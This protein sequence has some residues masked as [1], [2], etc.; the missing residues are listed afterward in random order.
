MKQRQ[1][2]DIN[3]YLEVQLSDLLVIQSFVIFYTYNKLGILID[4]AWRNFKSVCK[5]N[6]I[7]FKFT[8]ISLECKN[9]I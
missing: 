4:D 9:Y 7:Q 1:H 3:W 6:H 8:I 5:S 2:K